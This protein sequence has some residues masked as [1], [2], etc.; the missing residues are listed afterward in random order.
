MKSQKIK[1]V[2]HDFIKLILITL[3]TLPIIW[4]ITWWIDIR[5]E[6]RKEDVLKDSITVVGVITSKTTYKGK[7]VT[8][9]YHYMNKAYHYKPSVTEDFYYDHLEGDSIEVLIS[10][11]DP[12]KSILSDKVMR[13]KLNL[14]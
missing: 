5:F 7:G 8:I 13:K 6:Q 1:A 11:D 14:D 2:I 3:F 4:L 12:S 10:R 9:L